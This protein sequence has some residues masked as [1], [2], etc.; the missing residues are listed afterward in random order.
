MLGCA[1]LLA[2]VTF[3]LQLATS[4]KD[5]G[6]FDGWHLCGKTFADANGVGRPETNRA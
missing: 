2:L 1:V 5:P 6:V 4:Q 3:N